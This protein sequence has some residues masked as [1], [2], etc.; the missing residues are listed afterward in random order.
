MNTLTRVFRILAACGVTFVQSTHDSNF[1]CPSLFDS[2]ASSVSLL[3]LPQ[4]QDRGLQTL[5]NRKCCHPVYS[6]SRLVT[7]AQ[8]ITL[9]Q[10]SFYLHCSTFLGMT[11]SVSYNFILLTN[12]MQRISH[13]CCERRKIT[14]IPEVRSIWAQSGCFTFLMKMT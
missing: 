12:R 13:K 6:Y 2:H 5:R 9:V 3:L 14:H 10:Q 11:F 7:R 8:R 4:K 1:I